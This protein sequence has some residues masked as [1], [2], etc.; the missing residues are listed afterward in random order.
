MAFAV[1]GP[2]GGGQVAAVDRRAPRG[3]GHHG[4]VAEQLGEQAQVRRLAAPRAGTGEL[5]QRPQHG[6]ALHRVVGQ[7][8]AWHLGQGQEGLPAGPLE[9]TSHLGVDHGERP[10]RGIVLG[11]PGAHVHADGA[12]GA[13]VGSDL[14]GE[15]VVVEAAGPEGLG[16]EGVAPR[17]GREDLGWLGLHADG[18]VGAHHHATTAVDAQVGLPHG[19]LEGQA[20][21][22]VAGGAHR[23]GAVD[24]ERADREQVALAG[25]HRRGHPGH[26]LGHVLGHRGA[27]VAGGGHVRRHRHLVQGADGEVDRGVVAG[28]HVGTPPAVGLGEAGLQL[29]E[30]AVER[31]HAGEGEERREHHR[32]DPSGQSGLAGRRGG[33]RSPRAAAARSTISVCTSAGRWSHTSSGA[34]GALI[35]T[36]APG[37]ATSSTSRRSSRSVWWQATKPAWLDQV[38]G[39]DGT[40]GDPQVRHGDRAGLLGVVD[41]VALHVAVGVARR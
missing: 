2:R 22:L 35:S 18:G 13:V 23:E 11:V 6:G 8:G 4:P 21:L 10:V 3:V 34:H 38:G 5:E 31:Q 36:V 30:G 33:R 14:D 12:A 15:Q 1:A 40:V 25:Q 20:A 7:G 17:G 16:V 39:A 26:E 41:E 9:V 28:G 32:V 29:G 27:A 37:S 24:G 19:Q